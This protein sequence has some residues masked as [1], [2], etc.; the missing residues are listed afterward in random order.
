LAVRRF[1]YIT[2]PSGDVGTLQVQ[3]DATEAKRGGNAA[4]AKLAQALG[5]LSMMRFDKYPLSICGKEEEKLP[6]KR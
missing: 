5:Y 1:S 2:S 4:G 6:W 3:R